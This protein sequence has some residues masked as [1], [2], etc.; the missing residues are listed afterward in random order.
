VRAQT[1]ETLGMYAAPARTNSVSRLLDLGDVKGASEKVTPSE[2]F[3][4]ARELA[5][6]GVRIVVRAG[7]MRQLGAEPR[8]NYA[9]ISRAFGT[10]KP[11][12]ANSYE[13]ELLNLRTFPA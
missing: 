1:L 12:L 3:S 10:P 11:T 5:S 2:L 4:I 8:L 9:A 13:P 7:G 6:S